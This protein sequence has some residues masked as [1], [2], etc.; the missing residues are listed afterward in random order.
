MVDRVSCASNDPSDNSPE[1][2]WIAVNEALCRCQRAM[3]Q[4]LADELQIESLS[5]KPNGRPANAFGPCRP[6]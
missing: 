4:K 2:H 5:M 6:A 1:F 3:A